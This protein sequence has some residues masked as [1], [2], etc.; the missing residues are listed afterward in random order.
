MLARL[1]RVLRPRPRARRRSARCTSSCRNEGDAWRLGAGALDRY[2]ERVVSARSERR[3]RARRRCLPGTLLAAGRTLARTPLPDRAVD[4]IGP[5]L[6][7]VRLLGVRTARAAPGARV[8]SSSDP[9]FAP[10]P[11]DIMHQQS[12]YG[13]VIAH[14]RRARSSL[15]RTQL[16]A[17]P[18]DVAA[19][20]RARARARAALDRALARVTAAQDRRRPHPRRTATITSARCCGPATTS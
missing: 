19:A 13:S 17:L 3:R 10:E 20:R 4:W 16:R 8:A 9:L 12:I 5:V 11:Y 1:A 2:F 15:L 14:M 18:P 7:R 6:D